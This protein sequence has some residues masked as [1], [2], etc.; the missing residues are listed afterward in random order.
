[1]AAG[2]FN[3]T[4]TPNPEVEKAAKKYGLDAPSACKLA[5]VLESRDDPDE[6]LRRVCTHLE[7][8]NKPSA[9][10]MMMLKQ[11]K[12]GDAIDEATKTPAIGS[13]LHKEENK[14]LAQQQNR[15]KSRRRS[16]SRKQRERSKSR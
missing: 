1:M 16:G 15:S 3:G 2:V 8:S 14:K 6:D 13:Y 4:A 10:I 12:A 9:L 5:E 7:R 11:I